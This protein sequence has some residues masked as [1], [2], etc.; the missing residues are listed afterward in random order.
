MNR[1]KQQFGVLGFSIIIFVV[2]SFCAV[3]RG[4]SELGQSAA[5][6][7]Y[8]TL[9]SAPP[10]AFDVK[11]SAAQCRF[12]SYRIAAPY[13]T[14]SVIDGI[15]AQLQTQHWTQHH[16]GLFTAA[17]L[18]APGKWKRWTNVMGGRVYTLEEEWQ[19]PEAG[20]IYYK[21]WY[22][23]PDLKTLEV[24]ARY[25]S[26]EQLAHTSHYVDCR[27]FAP[28]TGD[29][30]AFSASVRVTK[31]EIVK[32]GYKVHVRIENTGSKTFLLPVD[33]KKDDGLPHLSASPEQQEQG[34][35]SAVD[36]E[37]LEYTPQVWID[38]KPGSFV[39]SWV[40]TVDFPEPNKRFGM[41]IRKVGHLHGPIRISLPYFIGPC[42][43]Q[44]ALAAK[45]PYLASSEP[46]DP[47][48]AYQ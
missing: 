13:P 33:G 32:D 47:P 42:D 17:E 12:L 3:S 1:S 6:D 36:N 45:K 4:A 29:D 5:S 24:D 44:D 21:F 30:P 39:E 31:M 41:C 18:S 48:L 46:V 34:K 37:C 11:S 22:H 10:G 2:L 14:N 38:V 35:W 26:A 20:V 23:S 9:Q 15:S 40:N 7:G 43:I 28:A 27:N 25:C 19:S 16:F 8:T